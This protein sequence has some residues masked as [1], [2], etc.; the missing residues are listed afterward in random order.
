MS[1]TQRTIPPVSTQPSFDRWIADLQTISSDWLGTVLATQP[2][3]PRTVRAIRKYRRRCANY[4]IARSAQSLASGL[5]TLHCEILR[6][7][8]PDYNRGV[9]R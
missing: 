9:T 3:K 4:A 1:E 2:V 7:S 8:F 5:Q 6:G